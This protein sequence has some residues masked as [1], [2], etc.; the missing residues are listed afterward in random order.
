[1]ATHLGT[2]PAKQCNFINATKGVSTR[3]RYHLSYSETP[4]AYI[5][6]TTINHLTRLNISKALKGRLL[7]QLNQVPLHIR[8]LFCYSNN[9]VPELYEYQSSIQININ[10]KKMLSVLHDTYNVYSQ[11]LNSMLSECFLTHLNDE[12]LNNANINFKIHTLPFD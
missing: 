8:C 1:M 7:R 3:L 11:K 6:T 12:T 4:T 2:K 10:C 9:N 5:A